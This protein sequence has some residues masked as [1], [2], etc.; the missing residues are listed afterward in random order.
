MLNVILGLG[1]TMIRGYSYNAT[2]GEGGAGKGGGEM[3]GIGS[4]G[5]KE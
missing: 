2:R 1:G 3:E 4:K 5:L